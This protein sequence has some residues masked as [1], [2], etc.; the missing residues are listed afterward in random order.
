M[1]ICVVLR[2]LTPRYNNGGIVMKMN[3]QKK[4]SILKCFLYCFL[5]IISGSAYAEGQEV[6][7]TTFYPTPNAVT[8]NFIVDIL[9][10]EDTT[11][12][13]G[14][15]FTITTESGVDGW[16][17]LRGTNSSGVLTDVLEINNLG[18]VFRKNAYSDETR[19]YPS[20][21]QPGILELRQFGTG[22]DST[23]AIELRGIPLTHT[24]EL[25][26]SVNP[27]RNNFNPFSDTFFT[28]YDDLQNGCLSAGGD[29]E[30]CLQ[31]LTPIGRASFDVITAPYAIP[32]SEKYSSRKALF[33]LNQTPETVFGVG[34]YCGTGNGWGPGAG[35][36]FGFGGGTNALYKTFK[37]SV[38][39][40]N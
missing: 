5:V 36:L 2:C 6:Q 7:M 15:V 33:L 18:L 21:Q 22:S 40:G 10:I 16:L 34:I 30:T 32:A 24:P 35:I 19:A 8:K 26:V 28:Q 38:Y 3:V 25:V 9:H 31:L 39:T 13:P 1:I 4:V 12:V 17:K 37:Y 14:P 29:P 27:F 23:P 11:G 20:V